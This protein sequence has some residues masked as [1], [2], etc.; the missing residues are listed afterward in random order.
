M[1]QFG[2]HDSAIHDVI[3]KPKSMDEESLTRHWMFVLT[4]EEVD[5]GY[6]TLNPDVLP[7]SYSTFDSSSASKLLDA[8]ILNGLG[9]LDSLPLEVL[10]TV[11]DET[12]VASI[13]T[14][15]RVNHFAKYLVDAH[16]KCK[17]LHNGA[18]DLLRAA[19]VTGRNSS[20]NDLLDAVRAADCSI[21]GDFAGFVYLPTCSP[22]VLLLPTKRRSVPCH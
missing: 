9:N 20:L 13:Q 3:C 14:F 11:L 21:C 1:A 18:A 19:I 6:R 4:H 15:H 16:P 17:A 7:R 5:N 8:S 22:C 12:D 10:E 2:V